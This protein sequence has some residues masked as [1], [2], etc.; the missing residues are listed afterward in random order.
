[1][2]TDEPMNVTRAFIEPLLNA[3]LAL[4]RGLDSS[5]RR[6]GGGWWVPSIAACVVWVWLANHERKKHA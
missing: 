6:S 4:Q 1:M 2:H 3:R 5:L